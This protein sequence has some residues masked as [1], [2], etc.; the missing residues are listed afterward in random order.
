MGVGYVYG[1]KKIACLLVNKTLTLTLTLTE[2]LT[3]TLTVTLT[4]TSY[5]QIFDRLSRPYEEPDVDKA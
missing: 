4:L 2:T 1:T 5:T 3:L